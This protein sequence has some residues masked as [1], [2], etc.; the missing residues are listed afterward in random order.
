MRVAINCRSILKKTSTG[1]GRYTFH[2]VQS[3]ATIDQKNAYALYCAHP[4]FNFKRRPPLRPASNFKICSDHFGLGADFIC[5][6]YDVYH[7]P[8]LDSLKKIKGKIVVT[9]HDMIYKTYPQ[10][11]TPQTVALSET[12]MQELV[13]RA[14]KIICI[15][16]ST[17]KDLHKFFDLP[18][19][20]SCVVY[21]GVDHTIFY[22]IGDDEQE[23]ANN[24]LAMHGIKGPYVLFVGTIEPRKNL[25]H[26]LKAFAILK[27]KH[28]YKGQLVIIGMKGWMMD[29]VAKVILDLNISDDLV[30]TGYV[31]DDQLRLFYNRAQVFAFPSFYEGFGFPLIEAFSCGAPVIT[32]NTSSC[33][34][35]AADAAVTIDPNSPEAI[36][37]AAACIIQDKD[38]QER[39][40]QKAFMRAKEFSFE[41]MARETLA[42]YQ[43]V[44]S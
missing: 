9:V 26:L 19:S 16:N 41:R 34:E 10:S 40:R 13:E 1:V 5:G 39:L 38:F 30:F 17:R 11:H 36:A 3:L 21:N 14:H 29:H 22:P 42:V 18:T 27:K 35:I 28:H 43:E 37:E 24:L 7:S 33:A 23:E 6:K 32:S 8:S 25:D 15:S 4:I 31:S 12:N 2:L 44:S 20:R